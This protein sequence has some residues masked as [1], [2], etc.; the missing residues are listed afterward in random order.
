MG[1]ERPRR[2]RLDAR[3]GRK[4]DDAAAADL[5]QRPRADRGVPSRIRGRR[6]QTLA[7][8]SDSSK[9][10]T[11][12]GGLPLRGADRSVFRARPRLSC[13]AWRVDSAPS[14]LLITLC[15]R[16]KG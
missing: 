6:Y 10:T 7:A 15:P 14:V 8:D 16:A 13:T 9:W 4:N 3:S 5:V 11:R 1:A 12:S 2:R